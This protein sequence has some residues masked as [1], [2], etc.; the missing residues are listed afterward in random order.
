MER[1]GEAI[2]AGLLILMLGTQP[3]KAAGAACGIMLT[4]N[5]RV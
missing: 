1:L 2:V 5:R 3:H 4:T